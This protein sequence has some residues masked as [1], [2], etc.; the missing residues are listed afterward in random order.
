MMYFVQRE[1]ALPIQYVSGSWECVVQ[2]IGT[3]RNCTNVVYMYMYICSCIQTHTRTRM[4]IHSCP[5]D[6]F[7]CRRW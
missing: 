3:T 6:F 4:L 1:R 7:C 5:V 2:C